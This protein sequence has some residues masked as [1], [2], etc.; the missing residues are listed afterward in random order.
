ML[1]PTGARPRAW[2]LAALLPAGMLVVDPRGYAPFGPLR[3]AVVSVV[4][5]LA[6]AVA[7]RGVPH[8]AR[9][10]AVAWIVFVAWVAV[11]AAL[12]VDPVYGCSRR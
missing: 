6:V 2:L 3:W 12:G 11:C 8:V 10:P 4:A 7:G 5:L 1:S 9:W